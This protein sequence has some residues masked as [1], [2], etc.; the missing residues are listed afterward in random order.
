MR[1][2]ADASFARFQHTR[3]PA[4][5]AA[6]FDA[7]APGLLLVAMHLCGDAADAEDL[8]QTVFL[9]AIRDAAAYDP[10]QP[11]LP[12]LLGILEHRASDLRRRA[13]R[14]HERPAAD[15]ALPARAVD[16]PDRAAASAEVLQQVAVALEGLPPAYREVLTLRLVHGLRAVDIARAQGASPETVRTRLKRGLVLLRR[17]LPKSLA[18]PLVLALLASESLR[19]GT[20]L[21]AVKQAV[22]QTLPAVAGPALAKWLAASVALVAAGLVWSLMPRADSTAPA[23]PSGHGHLVVADAARSDS[24]SPTPATSPTSSSPERREAGI[25]DVGSDATLIR[26]RFV[27]TESG[28]PLH[29]VTVHLRA[30]LASNGEPAPPGW[31]DPPDVVSG[32]DGRFAFPFVPQRELTIE[33]VFHC[34]GRVESTKHWAPLRNGLTIELG[35]LP[36]QPGTP[37]QLRVIEAPDR[38]CAGVEVFANLV[39]HRD[40]T[41]GMVGLGPT[42]AAGVVARETSLP[43]RWRYELRTFLA[44]DKEGEFELPLQ[45]TTFVHTIVLRRPPPELSISGKVADTSGV[46]VPGLELWL[47]VSAH[48][49]LTTRTGEDG[50]FLFSI[51]APREGPDRRFHLQLARERWDLTMVDNGGEFPWGTNDLALVV[52]RRVPA[53]LSLSVVDGNTGKPVE[54]FAATC[55]PDLGAFSCR[56][57]RPGTPEVHAGGLLHFGN[58]A[59]GRHRL[60]LFPEE[61]LA[62]VLELSVELRE[63]E[64]STGR[65]E[66]LPH[67]QLQIETVDAATQLPLAGVEVQLGR[68]L[69]EQQV[70]E[71]NL[72]TFRFTRD[73]GSFSRGTGVLMLD[74]ATSEQRGLATLR[75]ARGTPALV[76]IAGGERCVARMVKDVTLTQ[77]QNR[78]R[79]EVE[80]AASLSGTVVPVE[81]LRRFGPTEADLARAAEREQVSWPGPEQFAG[82]YGRVKLRRQGNDRAVAA[83]DLAPDGSFR[84]GSVPS[85]CFEAWLNLTVNQRDTDLGPLA[86]VDLHCGEAKTL[87]LDA[88]A[89]LPAR[90]KG[91]FF[92]DGVAWHG[93]AGFA[94]IGSGEWAMADAD[95]TGTAHSRW[96]LPGTWL[97]FAAVELNHRNRFVLGT[98]PLVL[99]PGADVEIT[100][101]LARRR[102]TVQLLDAAGRPA[103]GRRLSLAPLEYPLAW[104]WAYGE[105]ADANGVVTFDPAPPGLARLRAF[106]PEQDPNQVHE[107]PAALELGEVGGA[108]TSVKAQLPR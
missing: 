52:Q 12:W 10:R 37:F 25:G 94:R 106:A 85:G 73:S 24:P 88:G 43:G 65:I 54:R 45:G 23:A 91:H 9:Q 98:V 72:D 39:E 11:V 83:A 35:D 20:G 32:V 21:P 47:P 66:L 80:T 97:P 17:A 84:L 61:P 46:P 50:S 56:A 101:A 81:L 53:S 14:R 68:V 36:L 16:A 62:D 105:R 2:P 8:V 74:H 93:Q 1:P 41:H 26:G 31:R 75:A 27:A 89:F 104:A 29:G 78:M 19:A 99:A 77:P 30:W 6:V 92:V 59:P 79:I 40:K 87:A 63:G 57:V 70:G 71:V 86:L 55:R 64:T 18:K 22:L 60:C 13:H 103:A 96:L 3:D 100:V 42:D 67:A 58:L 51:G 76:V 108:E 102:L 28:N 5:L 48:G 82:N 49:Y 33:L 69:P 90:V 38:P 7:T 95:A 4:A 107:V 34:P 44:G 15:A